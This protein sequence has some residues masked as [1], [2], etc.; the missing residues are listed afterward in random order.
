MNTIEKLGKFESIALVTTIAL[1]QV[2]FNYP[3]M[4]LLNSGTGSWLNTIYTTIIALGIALLIYKLF[5][6][7][8]N[9]DIVDISEYCGGKILK[10]IISIM[11]LAFFVFISATFI[12]YFVNSMK[13]IYFQKIPL[14]F[15]LILFIIPPVIANKMGLKSI[16]GVDLISLPIT[17]I[18]TSILFFANL[19][20]FSFG[21]LFPILGYGVKNIFL[22][23]ITNIFCFTGLIYILFLPPLLKE[24]KTFKTTSIWYVV[25]SGIYLVLSLMALLMSFSSIAIT[26]ETLSIYL[27]ARIIRFGQFFQRIDAVFIFLWIFAVFSFISFTF[28]IILHILK[29]LTKAKDA[30]ELVYSLSSIVFA[31]SL[32]VTNISDAKHLGRGPLKYSV[33]VLLCISIALLILA[34]IKNKNNKKVN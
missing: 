16:A 5:K 15:L 13:I 24:H 32:F 10:F 29:K 28:F 26:D 19:R 31:S 21:N 34:N 2:I 30:K 7:F 12:R 8:P 33:I 11:F 25:F 17:L 4:L 22:Y 9:K 14:T 20:D 27:L 6:A 23:G 1:N 3:N 18:S